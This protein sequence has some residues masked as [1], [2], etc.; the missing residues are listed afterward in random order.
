V[1]GETQCSVNQDHRHSDRRNRLGIW[2][3]ARF[4]PSTQPFTV[5]LGQC[6]CRT[7]LGRNAGVNLVEQPFG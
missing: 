5:D 6:I 3:P 1:V 4:C 2:L 7:P